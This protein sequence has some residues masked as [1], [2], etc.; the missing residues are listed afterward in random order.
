MTSFPLR[1]LAV[2]VAA[3]ALFSAARAAEPAIIAKARAYVGPD[4]VLDGLKSIHYSGAIMMPDPADASKQTPSAMEM[5]IQKP[6]HNRVMATSPKLIEI[7]ALDSYDAW[8]RLQDAADPA[9]WQQSLLGTD[10]IK[11]L[12]ANTWENLAFY[13]G[14]ERVGG[15]VEDQGPV[16]IEGI[17]CQ[18]LAFIHAPGI[19]FYRFFEAATGRLVLTETENG[20]TIREQGE[21]KVNGIRFPKSVINSSKDA[22]GKT[23]TVTVVFDK[24]TLNEV[25]PAKLFAVPSLGGK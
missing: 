8:Q 21:I 20:S 5:I 6:Y 24:I 2:A 25:F 3:F 22:A 19:I 23:R 12:R 7:T 1:S 16:T 15:R 10:Q 9:K 13:R 11:R 17:A 18:K 4:A 14:I